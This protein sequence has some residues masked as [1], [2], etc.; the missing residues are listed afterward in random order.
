MT[1]RKLRSGGRVNS[2]RLLCYEDIVRVFTFISNFAED[3][4][5]SLP[6]RIPGFKRSDLRLLPCH[7][8]KID[9]YKQYKLAME[10]TGKIN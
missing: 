1:P 2:R 3:H 4:A 10:Q 9:V 7:I 6:G 5:V 8:A